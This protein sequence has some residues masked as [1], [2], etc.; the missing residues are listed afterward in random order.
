M[1]MGYVP[2]DCQIVSHVTEPSM[3][4][5]KT[6]LGVLPSFFELFMFLH[7]AKCHYTSL[8]SSVARSCL[9]KKCL[10]SVGP[11]KCYQVKGSTF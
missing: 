8:L 5:D 9:W 1:H 10:G 6:V 7:F 2:N 11:A 3:L 4:K